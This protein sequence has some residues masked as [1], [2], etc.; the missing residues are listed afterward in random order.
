MGREDYKMHKWSLGREMRQAGDV[1]HTV[2]IK[3]RRT[4]A[5]SWTQGGTATQGTKRSCSSHGFVVN[6]TRKKTRIAENG[7]TIQNHKT[8]V[9]RLHVPK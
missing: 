8:V 2:I 5:E 3:K 1:C 7:G 4:E 6:I 9:A